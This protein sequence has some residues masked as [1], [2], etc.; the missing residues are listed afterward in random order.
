[1][2]DCNNPYDRL[3]DVAKLLVEARQAES[4]KQY[5]KAEGLRA[6]ARLLLSRAPGASAEARPEAQHR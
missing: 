6:K 4:R 1:M 3:R 2:P 5:A